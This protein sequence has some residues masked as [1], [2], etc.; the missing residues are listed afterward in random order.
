MAVLD[1]EVIAVFQ[2][3]LTSWVEGCPAAD[4]A[5]EVWSSIKKS[6]SFWESLRKSKR[7]NNGSYESLVSNCTDVLI[8]GN[9]HFFS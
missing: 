9:L 6:V 3:C 1:F 5:L 7:P 4:R 8:P 2:A